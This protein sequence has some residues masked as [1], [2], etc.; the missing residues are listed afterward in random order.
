MYLHENA[1]SAIVDAG[2]TANYQ[3]QGRPETNM[4]PNRNCQSSKKSASR[5]FWEALKDACQHTPQHTNAYQHIPTH[6][7]QCNYISGIYMLSSA[8]ILFHKANC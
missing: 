6:A 2:T 1:I 7:T 5:V 4:F 8:Q 3:Y